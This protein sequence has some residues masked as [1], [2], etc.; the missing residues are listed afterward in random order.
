MSNVIQAFV[1]RKNLKLQENVN[2]INVRKKSLSVRQGFFKS[3][4]RDAAI[5]LIYGSYVLNCLRE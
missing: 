3:N 4:S 1:V 5:N 2:I